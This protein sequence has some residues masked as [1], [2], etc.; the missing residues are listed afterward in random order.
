MSTVKEKSAEL[1]AELRDLCDKNSLQYWLAP[2]TTA[3]AYTYGGYGEDFFIP[4]FVMTLDDALRLKAL[5]ESGAVAGRSIEC[6]ENNPQFT[7]FSM[8]Y[9]N[10]E[11]TLIDIIR[12]SDYSK[13]GVRVNIDILRPQA[14]DKNLRRQETLWECTGYLRVLSVKHQRINK[15]ARTY[16]NARKKMGGTKALYSKM[17]HKYQGVSASKYYLKMYYMKGVTLPVSMFEKNGEIEFEGEKYRVPEPVDEYLQKS[18]RGT[19]KSM[20]EKPALEVKTHIYYEYVPYRELQERFA[21]DGNSIEAIFNKNK[22]WYNRS[23]EQV[24]YNS[25][26]KRLWNLANRSGM[27]AIVYNDLSKQIDTIRSLYAEHNFAELEKIFEQY[28]KELHR[29]LD[30][31]LGLCPNKELLDIECALM[32]A[33]GETAAVKKL[34]A[35]VPE[36]HYNSPLGDRA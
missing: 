2:R 3:R 13:H 23:T 25:E 8:T 18:T 11:T 10:E 21:A 14:D 31:G 30:M 5:V 9:V 26:K 27:R 28:D 6:M 33:R 35:L 4:G 12:G 19:W 36:Q 29:L 16:V 7:T 34:R 24:K 17:C 1:L 20:L 32:E 22:D 15:P